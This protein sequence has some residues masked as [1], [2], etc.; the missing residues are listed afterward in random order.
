MLW[1]AYGRCNTRDAS[2]NHDNPQLATWIINWPGN[3][4][5]FEVREVK[6]A[7]VYHIGVLGK[8]PNFGAQECGYVPVKAEVIVYNLNKSRPKTVWAPSLRV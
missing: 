2:T 3:Y 5:G 7:R 4:R 8:K 1:K 6:L